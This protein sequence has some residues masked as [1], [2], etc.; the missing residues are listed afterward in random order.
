MPLA[1]KTIIV[2][3]D[4]KQAE[5]FTTQLKKLGATVI[6][7]PTIEITGPEK[8]DKI[9]TELAD[10]SK[11]DWIVFTSTN[12]VSY[13][14]E[15]VD[16]SRVDMKGKN[17][18]CVGKKT[19]EVLADF[20]LSPALVPEKFSA[21]AVLE[22]M[23]K[24][25]IKGKHILTPVSNLAAHGIENGLKA[26]GAIVKRIEVY[27]NVP[28]QKPDAELVHQKIS[29]GLIDCITFF[30]PSA[31]QAFVQLM[32][33]DV[34]KEINSRQVA[35]AVIGSTT[36]NAAREVHLKP[37]IRPVQSDNESFLQALKQYY[38]GS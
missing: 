35:I 5:P 15:F 1:G 9:R 27:K 13:F 25:D 19:A 20:N 38:S 30:S 22:A 10:I 17:I 32:G 23:R 4:A 12:A 26:L 16:A 14:F 3:R 2:T 21:Q 11:Y 36:A 7:F 24:F 37:I 6:L 34:V 33:K 8:P 18:A 31:L 28:Y 29:D